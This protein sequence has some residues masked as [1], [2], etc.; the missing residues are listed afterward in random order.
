MS[1]PLVFEVPVYLRHLWFFR[2]LSF[3]WAIGYSVVFLAI[4]GSWFVDL[5]AIPDIVSEEQFD[6]LSPMDM[7]INCFLIY[8]TIVH[9]SIIPIN[10]VIIAKEIQLQFF[11]FLN[12]FG[13]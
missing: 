10:I 11:E 4:Y 12:S 3:C 1:W 2:M 13:N 5:Y 6:K 9:F 8:N 7:M